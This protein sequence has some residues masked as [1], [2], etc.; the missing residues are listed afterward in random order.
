MS[1]I[2][3]Q[4]IPT[5][6]ILEDYFSTMK[7]G[8]EVRIRYQVDRKELYAYEKKIGKQLFEM[9]SDELFAMINTFGSQRKTVAGRSSMPYNSFFQVCSMYRQIFNYYI[10]NY[11]V[12]RNPFNEKSMKGNQALERIL[13]ITDRVTQEDVEDIVKKL[14]SDLPEERANYVECIIRLFCDGFATNEEI[15]LLKE[16]MIDFRN[17][18]V[19]MPN[20]TIVLKERTISLL[21]YVHSLEEID[22]NHGVYKAT[23]YRDYY[24]KYFVFPRNV[25]TFGNK[26][27]EEIAALISRTF[28]V[29]V[30]RPYGTNLNYRSLF[31]LGFYQKLVETYGEDRTKEMIMSVRNSGDTNDVFKMAR[32]YGVNTSNI[33][34]LRKSL[35]IYI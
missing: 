5:K 24:F 8:V 34:T 21:T 6:D 17:K 32:L 35:R 30:R 16:D 33:S 28:N 26:E 18:R 14:H 9:N 25:A 12:I 27:P 1:E 3:K 23:Q 7:K 10:E 20:R 15:V 29:Y 2:A 22:A 11:Q 31:L 4:P 13:Q 19:I